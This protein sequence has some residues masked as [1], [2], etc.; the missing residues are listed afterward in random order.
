[1]GSAAWEGTARHASLLFGSDHGET[2][3]ENGVHG[4]ARNVL[5]AV[6]AVPLVIRLPFPVEPI[7]VTSQVRNLDIAPTLLDLAGV[8]V[9]ES[10]EGRSL[11]PLLLAASRGEDTEGRATY[12]G[13]GLPLFSGCVGAGLHQH[14]VVD[15]GAQRRSRPEAR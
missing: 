5:T 8:E 10:F 12:A 14:R 13:L 3:G 1:M 7:R 9:P 2:F 4:H 11:V 6:V 15:D